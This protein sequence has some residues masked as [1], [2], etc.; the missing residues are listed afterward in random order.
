[1]GAAQ[2]NSAD[3][4][5]LTTLDKAVSSTR[6]SRQH[7]DGLPTQVTALREPSKGTASDSA[8][9]IARKTITVRQK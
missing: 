9:G 4:T 8:A 2:P 5:V 3:T 1:M 6:G 7:G